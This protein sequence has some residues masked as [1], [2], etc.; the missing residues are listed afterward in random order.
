MLSLG[1]EVAVD[2]LDIRK[3]SVYLPQSQVYG[4]VEEVF[5]D[6]KTALA[7]TVQGNLEILKELP[8]LKSLSIEEIRQYLE[9]DIKSHLEKDSIFEKS[10]E[11]AR[12][13]KDIS[14]YLASYFGE[15]FKYH[16]NIRASIDRSIFN[17]CRM[18]FNSDLPFSFLSVVGDSLLA[19]KD[20]MDV[21]D[22]R[23]HREYVG[24]LANRNNEKKFKR[25]CDAHNQWINPLTKKF[26]DIQRT[27]VKLMWYVDFSNSMSVDELFKVKPLKSSSLDKDAFESIIVSLKDQTID[28]KK[29]VESGLRPSLI[30]CELDSGVGTILKVGELLGSQEG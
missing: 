17:G 27:R 8:P 19:E 2:K 11:I 29:I 3:N 6:F 24:L 7:D 28:A 16:D 5:K 13:V 15:I 4:D 30:P 20:Y 12:Y 10:V 25:L 9:K 22:R 1:K 14:K 18:F 26:D 23:I 21:Y